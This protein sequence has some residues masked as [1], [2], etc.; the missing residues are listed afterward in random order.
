[1]KTPTPWK[2]KRDT[3]IMILKAIE[4]LGGYFLAFSGGKD[5]CVIKA[6]ADM[7]GVKYD[8]H[9]AVSGIDPPELVRFIKNYHSDVIWDRHAPPFLSM[10]PKKGFPI[11]HRRWCCEFYKE[12]GGQGRMVI[13]GIRRAESTTRTDREMLSWFNGK[14]C[15][16][17]IIDW[18]D[19]DVWD[20]IHGHEIPYCSLYDEGF[21]RLG[22]IGCPFQSASSKRKEFDRWPGFEKAYRVAFRKLYANRLESNPDAVKHW[23]SGD[24][25]FDWWV[26][27]KPL[28]DASQERLF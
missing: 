5:S 8:A 9:Y 18:T 20:F 11:R 17:I 4:P 15:F 12:G 23:K 13:L 16:N 14:I 21:K 28:S 26:S 1:M 24:E 25:M 6:L 10:L 2:E 22:C 19:A 3:A 7:A 27:N